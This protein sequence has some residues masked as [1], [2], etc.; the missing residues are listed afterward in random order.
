MME[1]LSLNTPRNPTGMAPQEVPLGI[2]ATTSASGPVLVTPTPLQQEINSDY[3][4]WSTVSI[5][6]TQAVGETLLDMNFADGIFPPNLIFPQDIVENVVMPMTLWV[7]YFSMYTRMTYDLVIQPV[8]AGDCRASMV[9]VNNYSSNLIQNFNIRTLV[10]HIY[11]Q[12]FDDQLDMKT[13]E[14]P[15]VWISKNIPN[16]MGIHSVFGD[17][18]RS[19]LAPRTRI[20]A[21]LTL[22]YQPNNVQ[23]D[24][25][26]LIVYLKF[27]PL[28]SEGL[29]YPAWIDLTKHKDI[30]RAYINY[31]YWMP[32]TK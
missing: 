25:M 21:K 1:Q 27:R 14:V 19:A 17:N 30:N 11:E 32:K 7:A 8:K 31:P 26:N 29:S 20:T 28:V 3:M 9:L 18:F 6:K 22:P 15:Q 16:Q 24:T 23:P 10:N 2:S 4:I 5:S 13:F 12:N